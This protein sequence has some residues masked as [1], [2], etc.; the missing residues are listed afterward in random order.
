MSED[1]AGAPQPGPE[2][3]RERLGI[4]GGTFD[5][6]HAG[7]LAAARAA[8][9]GRARWPSNRVLLVVAN[10]PWQKTPTRHITP[11]A[12]RLAL[13]EAACTGAEP[14][15]EASA[16]EI[17]RGGPSYTIETVEDLGRQARS[18]ERPAPDIYLVI[19][20]DLVPTLPTWH[21]GGRP[22]CA[23]VTLAVV[24]WPAQSRSP[25]LPEGWRTPCRWP[26]RRSTHRAPQV[27]DLLERHRPVDGLVDPEA[28][29]RC[30]ARRGL[31][32]VAR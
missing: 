18:S 19:G 6:P 3:A 22:T 24:T 7:H 5:P 25:V 30:I 31:Y 11:A 14:G 8:C 1:Q 16:I 4:L 2:G 17:E 32:A 12:D 21:R 27:R 20:S 15:V 29:I 9:Q 26:V 28:V 10:D 23:A 13:V